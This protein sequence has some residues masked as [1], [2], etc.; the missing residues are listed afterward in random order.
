MTV[1]I[2]TIGSC[3]VRDNFNTK[4][5]PYYKEY[6]N[7]VAHLQ[8]DLHSLMSTPTKFS[9]S[10]NYNE[11]TNFH[12]Q[13]IQNE[14]NKQFLE[15]LKDTNPD[16]IILDLYA[17]MKFDEVMF[18]EKTYITNNVQYKYLPEIQ[19]KSILKIYEDFEEYFKS[20]KNS[21]DELFEF[22][23]NELPKSKVI[24]LNAKYQ[25]KFKINTT[26][27]E[28]GQNQRKKNLDTKKMNQKWNILYNHVENNF[29]VFKINMK[30][31]KYA[32]NETCLEGSYY[33]NFES[34]FYKDF[35][36]ELLN[37]ISLDKLSENNIIDEKS[38]LFKSQKLHYKDTEQKLIDAKRVEVVT[39]SEYNLINL[40]RKNKN[41]YKLYKKLLE[42]D[43][44]LYFH[45]DGISKL[46]KRKYIGELIKRKD[47]LRRNEVFYTLSEPR[48]R[49]INN[50]IPKKL[51]VIFTCMPPRD[52]YDNYLI[53]DRM[54]TEFF[55]GIERNLVKNVYIMRIMDLNVS[56]G[57]HYI[58]T[59]NYPE[60]EQHIQQAISYVKTSL[61]IT[62]NNIVFYGVSKGGTGALFHGSRMDKKLL[63]VDPI[64]NIG[65]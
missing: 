20:W 32:L 12:K 52:K 7:L 2:A 3:V 18:D 37:I 39:D 10:D 34:K 24:L 55:E 59:I 28:H 62:E 41:A 47:L 11:A 9:K 42:K 63:A 49:K 13:H 6:F 38:N 64:L 56:H 4:F 27:D 8:S 53:H 65:G 33:L 54:F 31:D 61:E 45:K 22:F 23:R 26:L 1:K 48:D 21:V 50:N 36:F 43:Y 5:N 40:A 29:D 60:Y 57:S 58:N 16:Y 19:E 46:Y 14:I 17:D 25:S 35:L 51:L 44:I 30:V 15:R